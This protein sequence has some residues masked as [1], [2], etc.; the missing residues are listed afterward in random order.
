MEPWAVPAAIF[1]A[2]A[3]LVLPGLPAAL[4]LRLRPVPFAATL[5]P[6][7]L[8]LVTV[9]AELGHLLGVPWS[10]LGPLVLGLL[11]GAV[12]AAVLIPLRARRA[13]MTQSA[14]HEQEAP[15]PS[16]FATARG[17]ATAV[18]GGLV[19]GGGLILV[20]ALQVM[21]DVHA[22]SQTYDNVF[23]L[24]AIRHVLR[25]GDASAWVVGG[26]T[27]LEGYASYY[28]ALWHQAASLVAQL[29][30]QDIVL[31]S[32]VLM[33][34]VAAVVWPLGVVTLVRTATTAGPA[35]WFLA[36]A[37]AGVSG[38]FP[39]SLMS[40]GIVL[41]YFLSVALI[42]LVVT[43]IVHVA[44]LAEGPDRL[45][46][47]TVTV[48]LVASCGAVTIAHP[49]GVFVSIV[50]GL[51]ILVWAC[52]VRIA[53]LLGRVR[54][55]GPALAWL[56]PITL[57]AFVISGTLW[58]RARPPQTS[59][60]W[61]PNASL[62]EAIG[63]IGSLSPN[64]TPTFLPL[65]IVMVVALTGVVLWS[66]S[67]WLVPA[68]LGI[69]VLAVSA[70]ALPF[71]DLRYQLTGTWYSDN[72]RI[73]AAVM[74]AAVPVLAVGL[75]A[76]GQWLA[77][78]WP[79]L[80]GSADRRSLGPAVVVVGALVILGM[81]LASDA[82]RINDRN[83]R[84]DWQE[85]HLLSADER[86]LLERLPEVV[87]EGAVIATNAWN[88]S[89]LA[90]AISDR[91]VLNT[92]MGFQ[93]EP[94]VH[95]L[96]AKLD[97]ANSNPEVCDAAAELNVEYALDFGPRELHERTATYTGLNEISETGAA[98]EVL[99]V[100]DAVLLRMLPCRGTDGSMNG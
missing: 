60:V 41:P 44:G 55:A 34:L 42:P 32:N 68:W 6:L 54:G 28:P 26:M 78:A 96:N 46:P 33:L 29:S 75:D 88:G 22:V 73:S 35:G 30:G 43:S 9:A 3:V 19:L 2:L 15:V 97:E 94:E 21:G 72:Y 7:S 40:W 86:E 31:S 11:L 20:R 36:G 99:R 37:L 77:E 14:A 51:P 23:H 98:E 63:Q 64:A 48:L 18:L 17:Q 87:P 61:G 89:S 80:R 24:N 59:A 85:D 92:Y 100:G 62:S 12:L 5:I 65:G 70:R 58:V 52:L 82:T 95:L 1:A 71:G 93:A 84:W 27:Q 90:Y 66:R 10:L 74:I 91:D 49:Q 83:L 4:V 16:F 39:L 45:R 79:A 13:G 56:A 38:S 53:G 8:L 69:A 81:S 76:V 67:R 57:V 50:I 25:N 47:A